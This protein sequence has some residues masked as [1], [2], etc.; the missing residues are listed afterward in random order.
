MTAISASI[1]NEGSVDPAAAKS[2]ASSR[3]HNVSLV[4]GAVL[5]LVTMTEPLGGRM[6]T[7]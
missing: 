4:M 5:Q 6:L 3:T 2:G 1:L 7:L